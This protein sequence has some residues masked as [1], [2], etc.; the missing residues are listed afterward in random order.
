MR[1]IVLTAV[2]ALVPGAAAAGPV[3]SFVSGFVASNSAL[4]LGAA[5]T[6]GFGA[7]VAFGS[8]AIGSA[9]FSLGAS[10]I[11]QG[12]SNMFR[13]EPEQPDIKRELGR[14][15]SRP[16]YR[17]AY[18]HTR[19]AG[20]PAPELVEGRA[21]YACL[22]LS[23]R[24]SA[25]TNVTIYVDK[26]P[27]TIE[28][29]DLF[30]FTGPGADLKP[31]GFKGW[32]GGYL[33]AWMGLGDQTGPPDDLMAE[34]GD[35]TA[36]DPDKLWPTDGWQ[37]RTVLWVRAEAGGKDKRLKRWPNVPPQFEVEADWTAVWDPRDPAQDPD[38]ETTWSYSANQ[39][40]VLLDAIRRNPVRRHALEQV[41]RASFEAAADV[42]DE[43]VALNAGGTEPRYEAHGVLIWRGGELHDRLR[44]IETAGAGR[45]VRIGGQLGYAPGAWR[46]PV[47][48]MTDI[49]DDGG[50]DFGVLAPSRDVPSQ[51][52]AKFT[53]PGRDWQVA[54]LPPHDVAGVAT[55]AG[56]DNVREINVEWATSATQAARVQKIEA[57]R[58]ARQRSLAVTLP[59]D[60]IDLVGGANLDTSLPAGFARLAGAWQV[61]TAHPGIW[62][63]GD[64][65]AMRVP[66]TLREEAEAIYAWDETTDE[67]DLRDVTTDPVLPDVAPPGA[68]AITVGADALRGGVPAILFD[69]PE[70]STAS[71]T[72]YPWQWRP[73]GG[74]WRDG[75]TLDAD[76]ADGGVVPGALVNVTANELYDL[77][78]Y[79]ESPGGRSDPVTATGILATAGPVDVDPPVNG[80]ATGGAGEIAVEWTQANAAD[81]QAVEIWGSDTDDVSAASLL[82]TIFAGPNVGVSYTE[83]GLSAAQT[84]YYFARAT[85]PH[86]STSAYTAS[87]S[88]TTDP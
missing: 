64:G 76:T 21:Y 46:A 84:R 28:A 7:G 4:Y 62:T 13:E 41:H 8:S 65:V 19:V 72:G 34:F 86:G 42:A 32:S 77:R 30:D 88:A 55:P 66:V 29:G 85:G 68:L 5:G 35:A 16:P 27:C 57:E 18:G 80:A 50:I 26:R 25:G 75:G 24:P 58:A 83:T 22:I 82:T 79:A 20:T 59:P 33:Y 45:L 78:V 49:L 23:S 81:V 1:L 15:Q 67:P 43:A 36:T 47:Y 10:A 54:E 53:A 6:A 51:V 63:Q 71:V 2:L 3:L 39:S 17:T 9:L 87:V 44:P 38:D 40:L 12:L 37:G 56:S 52:K 48:T 11:L 31:E 14:P 74:V 60:A 70:S 61:Q 73:S 69:V